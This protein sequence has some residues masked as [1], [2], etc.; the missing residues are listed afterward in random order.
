MALPAGTLSFRV[1]GYYDSSATAPADTRLDFD[2]LPKL[3]AT[4]G[5]GYSVRGFTINLAYAY[6]HDLDRVVT[7]G[8]IQPVNGAANGTSVDDAGNPLPA[9]NNGRYHGETHIISVGLTFRFDE[10]VHRKRRPEWPEDEAARATPARPRLASAAPSPA[11][12]AR[13]GGATTRRGAGG[14]RGDGA[15]GR[16]GDGAGGR[17]GRGRRRGGDDASRP[18]P[19]A[20]RHA[21]ARRHAPPRK[22]RDRHQGRR[23]R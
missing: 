21:R 17:G 12:G 3:A 15:G 23:S 7:N 11:L 6:V 2:T 8:D 5:L 22:T 19:I 4:F 18:E 16:R 10:L 1:G 14:R 13:A 20:R 9:V